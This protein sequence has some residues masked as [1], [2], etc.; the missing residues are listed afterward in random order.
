W[1]VPDIFHRT[2]IVLVLSAPRGCA[3]GVSFSGRVIPA[4]SAVPYL[5]GW[6]E[7]Q[8]RLAAGSAVVFPQKAGAHDPADHVPRDAPEVGE[9]TEVAGAELAVVAGFDRHRD[10]E[11]GRASC[12]ERVEILVMEAS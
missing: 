11:I 12:R 1:Q 7:D 5:A 10:H 2:S 8:R 3:R 4:A 9:R 6:I